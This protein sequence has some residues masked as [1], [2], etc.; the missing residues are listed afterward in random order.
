[1]KKNKIYFAMVVAMWLAISAAA[2]AADQPEGKAESGFSF[3]A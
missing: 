3:A 2:L 1:M